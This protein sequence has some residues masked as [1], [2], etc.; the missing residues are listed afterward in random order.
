[1]TPALPGPVEVVL[2]LL[3]LLGAG[4]II[5]FTLRTQVPPMPSSDGARRAILSLVPTTV[6]GPIH[7][8]G[9]GFGGLAAALSRQRPGTLVVGHEVSP[10]PA[11]YAWVA[12]RLA[13]PGFRVRLGRF[14]RADLSEAGLVVCYLMPQQMEAVGARLAEVLRPGTPVI[15]CAFAIPGWSPEATATADDLHRT[16]VYR[17]RVG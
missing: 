10:V 17:Y 16:P 2:V 5:F 15:S 14:E 4:S 3:V 9:C 12:G 13:R 11:L 6:G 7:E 1:M 8:L